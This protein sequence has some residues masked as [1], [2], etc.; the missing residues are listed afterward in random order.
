MNIVVFTSGRNCENFVSD[1]VKSVKKQTLS[2][3][4][5]K[6]I[7]I[8]DNSDDNTSFELIKSVNEKPFIET[9]IL[10]NNKRQGWVKNAYD[11]LNNLTNPFDIIVQLDMDDMLER[12]A[13]EI[14]YKQYKKNKNLLMTYGSWKPLDN[15]KV[16]NSR[17]ASQMK[18]SESFRD[19]WRYQHLHTFKKFL[20]SMIKEKDLKIRGEWPLFAQDRVIYYPM[21]EM[22]GRDRI[23]FIEDEIYLY[24]ILNSVEYKK[25]YVKCQRDIA[26]YCKSKNKYRILPTCIIDTIKSKGIEYSKSLFLEDLK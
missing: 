2:S 25:K 1:C 5:V 7:I 6:H 21:L 24:R 9:L 14:V 12:R 16:K 23:K 26:N 18:D 3:V 19:T 4:S 20:F 8:D 10:L 17:K 22:S 11:Y 15:V 13:L